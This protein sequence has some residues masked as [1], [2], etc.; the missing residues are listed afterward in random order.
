MGCIDWPSVRDRID[1]AVVT[2][3]L[4]GPA[5]GR[6]GE[7]GRRLWWPCPF[8]QD[9]NP[10]FCVAPGKAWWRCYGCGERGDAVALVMK[11]EGLTFPKAVSFLFGDTNRLGKPKP[12]TKPASCSEPR[13]HFQAASPSQGMAPEAALTLVEAAAAR[14]WTPE[15]GAG[16]AY[17]TGPRRCLKP[18]TIRAAR[19]GWTPRADGVPWSPPGVVIP[20]FAAG[21]LALVKVRPPD[22]W[23][24]RFP[25]DRR[26][27]KYIQA[28][29]EPALA[30]LYPGPEAIRLGRPLVIAEGEPDCLL[31]GQEL[32]E[33]ASIVTLGSASS[34]RHSTG[35]IAP[36]ILGMLLSACPWYVATDADSAGDKAAALW[37]AFPRAQRVRPPGP[38]KDW[39][40]A[41]TDGVDLSRWWRDILAGI[42]R[43]PLFTWNDLA[44]WRWGPA[45]G[46]PTSGIV[47]GLPS[48]LAEAPSNG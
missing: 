14:L 34:G 43:P 33:L 16:L 8:H 11:L 38:Y 32:G 13:S 29:R 7:R 48:L 40:E 21:R 19:L 4:L 9:N 35:G 46:D 30:G 3:S 10:S 39:T 24:G 37:D 44:G 25:E 45:P 6:R 36:N 28:F 47:I 31:L 12:R 17:L 42:D 26:P 2:T 20:W 23:R 5:P 41:A 15:G 22:E 1:L 18:E 27:P